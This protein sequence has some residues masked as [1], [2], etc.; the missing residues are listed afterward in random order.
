MSGTLFARMPSTSLCNKRHVDMARLTKEQRRQKMVAGT[1][2]AQR[3]I[4]HS[5]AVMQER[6]RSAEVLLQEA[7]TSVERGNVSL[8]EAQG[9]ITLCKEVC[10]H[11]QVA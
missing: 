8:T 7:T 9:V 6:L 2:T 11:A 3:A 5:M 4:D 1:T 10:G